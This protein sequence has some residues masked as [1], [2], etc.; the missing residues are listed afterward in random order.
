[1]LTET[2]PPMAKAAGKHEN[3][4]SSLE[5]RLTYYTRTVSI[6]GVNEPQL[7]RIPTNKTLTACMVIYLWQ[8]EWA[9]ARRLGRREAIPHLRSR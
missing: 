5:K 4:M 3:N 7:W 6:D 1:M 2:N 8:T 9:S